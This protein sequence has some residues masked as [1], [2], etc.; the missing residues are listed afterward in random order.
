ME[1]WKIIPSFPK[2][3]ASTFGQ[4]RNKKTKRIRALTTNPAG[5][6]IVSLQTNECEE[7]TR[8]VHRLVAEAF[9]PNPLNLPTVNHKNM[10]RGDNAVYN[11][12]W[13]SYPQQAMNRTN[14]GAVCP[15][16]RVP[17]E[18]REGEEWKQIAKTL[19]LSSFGR[20]SRDNLKTVSVLTRKADYHIVRMD[21]ASPFLHRLVAL[22]FVPNDDPN[23]KT[24]V[25]H[26]DGNTHNNT[27]SNLE[28]VT[29]KRSIEHAYEIGVAKCVNR[30]P[31]EMLDDNFNVV[32]SFQS[33]K[34]ASAAM[35]IH[36]TSL[37][38]AFEDINRR[39]K[40]YH[41]RRVV[42]TATM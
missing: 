22:H 25:N 31:V 3:E 24:I 41:W 33:L 27:A 21:G 13:A 37:Y 39:C 29:P 18:P 35:G 7:L 40:G 8:Y 6:V 4:I 42:D 5:Y 32:R 12:E 28:W 34:E 14:K 38:T 19:W 17:Y 16:T 26:I 1:E 23:N 9:I 36:F 15:R 2:Y 20:V 11:L 30:C 10:E